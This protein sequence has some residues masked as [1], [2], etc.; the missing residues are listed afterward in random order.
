MRDLTGATLRS[1]GAAKTLRETL[2]YKHSVPPGL[3]PQHFAFV[4]T[5]S[6]TLDSSKLT[7]RLARR[8]L[9]SCRS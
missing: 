3:K 1:Y 2:H 4:V 8:A 7:G 5:V 9:S 6:D